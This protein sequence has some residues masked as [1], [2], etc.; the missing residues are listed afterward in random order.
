METQPKALDFEATDI[1][2]GIDERQEKL[3]VLIAKSGLP[4]KVLYRLLDDCQQD[5]GLVE[6]IIRTGYLG[7]FNSPADMAEGYYSQSGKVKA[8]PSDILP[9][10][11]WYKLGIAMLANGEVYRIEH[12]QDWYYFGG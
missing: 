9:Y 4:V 8:I 6:L 7:R 12:E 2:F 5:V 11:G 3:A 10:V 1:D